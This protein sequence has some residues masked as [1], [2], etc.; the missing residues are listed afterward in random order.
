MA[1]PKIEFRTQMF[2][3]DWDQIW[4]Q[5][6][7]LWMME[8]LCRV[9]QTHLQEF[10]AFKKRGLVT[11]NYPSVYRAGLHYE[12]EKGT[13]IW[14][15]IPS[16]LQGVMGEGIYPGIWGDCVPISTLALREDYTVVP[17]GNLIPGDRI[18][19]DGAFT[20]VIEHGF[21]GEKP[22]LSFELNNGSVLRCSPEHRLF[23]RSGEERRAED[24]KPGDLLRTPTQD[25]ST[26]Q[27]PLNPT[28]LSS[29]DF[30][31]L[32]GVHVADGWTE[33]PRSPRFS[34]SGKDGCKKEE[35]KRRVE[36]LMK[37]IDV[38]TRWHERYIAV[39]DKDLAEYM[40]QCGDHAP[41][42][43]LPSLLFS[44]EQIPSIIEGLAADSSLSKTG[45]VTHGTTSEI[46]ALQLRI[47]YRM[48]GQSVHIKR[49][50][51]HGGLGSHPIYRVTV[52]QPEDL[53]HPH[54]KRN[55][56]RVVGVREE[57]PE[58]C[59]DITTDTGRFYL[60]ESDLIVHN[61]EDFACY[62]VAELRELPWHYQRPSS[63][64]GKGAS[65]A[66]G[67]Q[68][69]AGA[70]PAVPGGGKIEYADPNY[71]QED[72]AIAAAKAG[73][74]WPGW[75]RVEKGIPA[76]PFAKW[77]RGPQGQYHYHA[78]TF[79]PDGRLEDPSLVLGMGREKEFSE[80][81]MAEKLK[82][83]EEPV[84]L[85]YAKRPDVMVVDPEKPSGYN[86]GE[87]GKLDA[88]ILER[89]KQETAGMQSQLSGD[90]RELR[91]FSGNPVGN[92]S[93]DILADEGITDL[94]KLM[95][96]SRERKE[97]IAYSPD[98]ELRRL[99]GYAKH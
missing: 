99:L 63:M 2:R 40:K 92:S 62:R 5:K 94:D 51:E 82:T 78:L 30:A 46:L 1:M 60:P 98:A 61:C 35:Q 72:S 24:I 53:E 19:G 3:G 96:W 57:E 91:A 10:A 97:F 55:S 18:M 25:F 56:A 14:P 86:G 48:Q 6:R 4:S 17:F 69:Q 47:L 85:Q 22:I 21:T 70:G 83:G 27:T 50:D 33:L 9:N 42:K 52:R 38:H 93:G 71:P 45:T 20:T 7:M 73:K 64:G 89:L 11:N 87:S 12:T 28:A 41:V 16:M 88:K 13:E 59:C 90:Q 77:R 65:E 23:L 26:A 68:G 44:K 84:V 67:G 43:H 8:A 79:I 34:I 95:G 58:M 49:W 54:T 66:R 75:K 29:Q 76:K 74:A 37:S 39:N 31:W 80:N 36:S 32:L 81:N 15:D